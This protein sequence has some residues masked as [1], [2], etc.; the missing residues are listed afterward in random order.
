MTKP[1][2]E[3]RSKIAM[4]RHQRIMELI[5]SL[6]VLP[7]AVNVPMRIMQMYRSTTSPPLEAFAEVI[8][9]DGALSAKVLELSNSAWFSRTRRVTRISDALRMIG[10][11]N[12]LPLLFGVSLAAI[13][14]KTALPAEERAALW[15]TSM[16]KGIIASELAKWRG[17]AAAEEAFLC[18]V[19][20]DVALPTMYSSDRSSTME[21]AAVLD[22]EDDRTRTQ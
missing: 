17:I 7:T 8:V 10:L 21:L 2:V 15:Q 20:Q 11:N 9:T 19:L 5:A 4:A 6:T 22:L 16:L 1:P 14:N 18:G 13:F 12:L 3:Y